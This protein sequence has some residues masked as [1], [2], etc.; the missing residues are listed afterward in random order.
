MVVESL[1][2]ELVA[3]MVIE[4]VLNTAFGVPVIAPE[5]GLSESP[6]GS[7]PLVIDQEVDAPPVLVGEFVPIPTF[8]VKVNG[9]PA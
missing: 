5:V 6:D 1:P 3:S 4:A 9:E 7:D 8:L 2:P